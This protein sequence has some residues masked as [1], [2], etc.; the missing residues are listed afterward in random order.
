MLH[1]A[2]SVGDSIERL[3]KGRVL[4]A[5]TALADARNFVSLGAVVENAHAFSRLA[6]I[7]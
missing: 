6:R 1:F 4:G 7:G 5:V 3:K 2:V